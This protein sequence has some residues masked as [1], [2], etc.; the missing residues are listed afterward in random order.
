MCFPLSLRN[1]LNEVV[2]DIED[3]MQNA[4]GKS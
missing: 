4:V 3:E 2:Y 1:R